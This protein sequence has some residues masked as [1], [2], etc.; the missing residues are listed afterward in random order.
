MS[1]TLPSRPDNRTGRGFPRLALVATAV[2]TVPAFLVGP[3]ATSPGGTTPAATTAATTT[4]AASTAAGSPAAASAVTP[5]PTAS[6]PAAAPTPTSA[7]SA[8]AEPTAEPT[9]TRTARVTQQPWNSRNGT[10]G[11]ELALG[12]V[13]TCPSIVDQQR[14]IWTFTA[15]ADS[16]TLYAQLVE[17]SG[18]S[19]S[20]QVTDSG[21]TKFCD[22]D[23]YR[24]YLTSCRLGSAGSYT[25]TVT[26]VNGSRGGYT[27]SVES[28]RAPS[29]CA[30]L[31]EDVFSWASA[32]LSGTYPAGLAA[33]CFTFD[34][35]TGTKLFIAAP[36]LRDRSGLYAQILDAKGFMLCGSVT[37]NSDCEL[38]TAGPYRLF[39][40]QIDGEA[41]PYALRLPRISRA[42][43]CATLPLAP[44]GDPG[45]AIGQGRLE[46]NQKTCHAFSITT[47][48]QVAVR[49]HPSDV[50]W[51][52]YD[53]TG[54]YICGESSLAAD[55]VLAAAGKYTVLPWGD[56]TANPRDYQLTVTPTQH[57]EGCAP[58]VDT[59][60]DQATVSARLTSVV[61]TICHPFQG[62][63][64]DRVA[65]YTAPVEM[66][67]WLVGEGGTWTCAYSAPTSGG[68]V[69]P[70]DGTYRVVWY[71]SRQVTDSLG[72]TFQLQIRR[73]SDPTGCPALVPGSYDAAPVVGPIRCRTVEIAEAGDYRL[74]TVSATNQGVLSWLYDHQGR[75]VC[76]APL[77]EPTPPASGFPYTCAL[78]TA[79]RYTVVFDPYNVVENDVEYAA[80]L[81]PW[82]PSGCAS[83]SDTGWRDAAHRLDF[84]A[85]GQ[86]NCLR[87]TSPA[88]A[89][90]VESEPDG[91]NSDIVVVDATG[92][93]LCGA[94]QL[95]GY[96]CELTGQA[97]FYALLKGRSGKPADAYAVAFSRVDGPPA[98]PVLPADTTV[99][100]GAD[101]FV[102]CF[103]IP[104][105]QHAATGSVT[106]TRTA[107]T[108]SAKV[109][110]FDS[111][112]NRYC[113][114]N[115]YDSAG[116]LTC[117][118]PVGP[119]TVLLEADGLDAT[120]R[121]AHRDPSAP[122]T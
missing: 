1:A 57:A 8:T 28:R 69:L 41:A 12:T 63:A 115:G 34:Q 47:P 7:A 13:E 46:P 105:D 10:C 33:R 49:I 121:L 94:S 88:G 98:C 75:R 56:N 2:L 59:G 122:T 106:W 55:C 38:S 64:G 14:N 16:D 111:Q 76:A 51:R 32:G 67:K 53:D 81:L 6:A 102:T 37:D 82:A 65:T 84:P 36:H 50:R 9:R 90:I 107:G 92:T 97:P 44:F 120:Y 21:G 61:Q 79:G 17:L 119:L 72:P 27:L 70:A 19:L 99:I 5:A 80:A 18:A 104:A 113:R 42:V 43:G 66:T 40:Q 100:T 24:E 110:V 103:S 86:I 29:A 78:S 4:R 116:T 83:V 54:R 20:A 77:F 109:S 71:P 91:V 87:L 35:P 15:T 45:A 68:C 23:P 11:G 22:I 112:G 52:L 74:R 108:G 89:R 39:L 30:Q 60:W 96:S 85:A 31:P 73:I 118:L 101:R 95:R 58:A 26:T 62:K 3:S 117:S 25:I 48:G 93:T 114:P